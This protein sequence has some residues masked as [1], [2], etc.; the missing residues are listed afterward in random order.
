MSFIGLELLSFEF[1][2]VSLYYL[3]VFV[4]ETLNKLITEKNYC[5]IASIISEDSSLTVFTDR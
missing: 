5:T 3:N 2:S 1:L 4:L